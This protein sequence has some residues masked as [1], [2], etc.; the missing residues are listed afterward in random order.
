MPETSTV[1][2]DCKIKVTKNGP[3]IVSGNIPLFYMTI[4]CDGQG[5]TPARWV[6]GD[7]LDTSGTYALCRC[8]QS[9]NK[10]FCDGT[11][12][13]INFDGTE[14]SENEPFEQL[15]KVLD[16]PE[17]KLKDAELLCASARFCHRGGDIWEQI[18]ESDKPKIRKNVIAN[19]SD[20]PSGRLVSWTKKLGLQLNLFCRSR[21]ESSKIQAKV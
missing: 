8:G 1:K 6:I 7:R 21:L 4:E 11:H 3:Y 16:G 15:A 9:A 20:C 2:D 5:T 18:Y 10:P 19:A 13:K 12:V 17:L 14:M